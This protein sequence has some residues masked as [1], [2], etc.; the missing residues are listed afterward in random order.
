MKLAHLTLALA[1]MAAATA[2]TAERALSPQPLGPAL[3]SAAAAGMT[4]VPLLYVVDG[5]RL[6]R[7]QVPSLSSEQ[8]SAVKVLKGR[9]ALEQYGPDASY[10]VV[11]ITTKGRQRSS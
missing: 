2:C 8:I 5:V 4:Q 9:A 7:D 10:G 11:L 1:F 6:G 3:T